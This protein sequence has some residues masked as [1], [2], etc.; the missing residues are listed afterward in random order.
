MRFEGSKK[1]NNK[2][3]NESSWANFEPT[4]AKFGPAPSKLGLVSAVCWANSTMCGATLVADA[5]QIWPG[6]G[7]TRALTHQV[8]WISTDVWPP[9]GA[10]DDDLL[11][12]PMEQR[13]AQD[14]G[15][16]A[17]N[18]GDASLL[19]FR[20]WREC[21]NDPP[22]SPGSGHGA[23]SFFGLPSASPTLKLHGQCL[24]HV[25]LPWRAASRNGS[26][27]P[28]LCRSPSWLALCFRASV[29]RQLE[30]S[31][32]GS[33]GLEFSPDNIPL[34]LL[35]AFANFGHMSSAFRPNLAELAPTLAHFRLQCS[36]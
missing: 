28:E 10:R 2:N 4:S 27:Q 6:I 32:T 9:G 12:A 22:T 33:R 35:K 11:G 20:T 21:R 29:R 18:P 30:L 7:Q 26:K 36:Q 16:L 25:W 15:V 24:G 8:R 1:T 23:P 17:W 5:G 31:P 13:R 14:A 3:N 34:R 19:W